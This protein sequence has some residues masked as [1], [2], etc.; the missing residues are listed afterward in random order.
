MWKPT[1]V[2][3]ALVISLIGGAPHPSPSPEHKKLGAFVGTWKEEIVMTAATSSPGGKVTVTETCEW[4]SGGFS[5]VC[6]NQ[7]GVSDLKGMP[8]TTSDVADLKGLQI[9]TYDADAK[10]YKDYEFDSYGNNS[11]ATGT[12]EGDTFTWRSEN[13]V[14]GKMVKARVTTKVVS[15]DSITTK[16][17]ALDDDGTW[18]LLSESKRNREK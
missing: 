14:R 6:H 18:K 16:T 7:M 2:L 11:F 5:V 9:M 1:S 15:P 10:A 17:E 12:F 4:F 13:K 8:V 3:I